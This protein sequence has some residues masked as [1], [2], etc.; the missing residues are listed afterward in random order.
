M[1][2]Y[3]IIYIWYLYCL[4]LNTKRGL[5]G[6]SLSASSVST[7]TRAASSSLFCAHITWLIWTRNSSA[8]TE[9]INTLSIFFR[10]KNVHAESK[11]KD[12]YAFLYHDGSFYPHKKMGLIQPC[13]YVKLYHVWNTEVSIV[14][15]LNREK[16]KINDCIM[17]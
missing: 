13:N 10:K 11:L 8:T 7:A 9:L 12:K 16:R 15:K 2:N 4:C 17:V 14:T 5:P 6:I 3:Y 1:R